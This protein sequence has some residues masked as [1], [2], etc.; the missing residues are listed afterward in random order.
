MGKC[1][2]SLVVDQLMGDWEQDM[3]SLVTQ[4][5]GAV[6]ACCRFFDDFLALFEG[7]CNALNVRVVALDQNDD[8]TR[9]TCEI[10]DNLKLPSL[11]KLIQGLNQGFSTTVCPKPCNSN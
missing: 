3:E 1:F 5:G 4:C 10:E 9:A 7:D 6:V 2:S 11:E 8:Q